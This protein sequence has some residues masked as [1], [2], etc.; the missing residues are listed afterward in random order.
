MLLVEASG[1]GGGEKCQTTTDR[2]LWGLPGVPDTKN[3]LGSWR[4]ESSIEPYLELENV[5]NLLE[6]LLKPK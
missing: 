1:G 3:A 6:F 5:L 2:G 4:K